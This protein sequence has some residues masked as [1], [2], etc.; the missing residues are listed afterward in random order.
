M[1]KELGN[2]EARTQHKSDYILHHKCKVVSW[3]DNRKFSC[4]LEGCWIE[5]NTDEKI[6]VEHSMEVLSGAEK[7]YREH[8]RT[9]GGHYRKGIQKSL[10]L[11]LQQNEGW[12]GRI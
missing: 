8:P 7:C 6:L 1:W 5:T 9:C 11:L 2:L 3:I 4:R 10:A 12:E